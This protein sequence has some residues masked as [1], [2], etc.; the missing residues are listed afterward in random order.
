[1]A[2][3]FVSYR[4]KD[5]D[6]AA[7]RICD[8][9]RTHFGDDQVFQDVE[10]IP[11]GVDFREFVARK[12]DHCDV[13]LVVMGDD[14]LGATG[15]TRR[16]DRPEDLVRLEVETAL[17]RN[18][19]VIPVLVGSKAVP[20]EAELPDTL[21]NLAYRNGVEMRSDGSFDGQMAKLLAAIQA[22]V[23]VRKRGF[24]KLALA[25]AL[26]AVGIVVTLAMLPREPS[27]A[28]APTYGEPADPV[29]TASEE[30]RQREQEQAELEVASRQLEE[31][32]RL[33]Q[34]AEA[35]RQAMER[36]VA[37]RAR[38]QREQEQAELEEANRQLEEAQR[39]K[40]EAEAA[41]LSMEREM[42][43]RATRPPEVAADPGDL[44]NDAIARG[45][46]AA[47]LN[48]VRPFAEAGYADAQYNLGV[49]HYQGLGTPQD[50]AEALRWFR[51]AAEQG[52]ADAQAY[53]NA[54]SYPSQGASLNYVEAGT[55]VCPIGFRGCSAGN[56]C[57][58]CYGTCGYCQ[59]LDSPTCGPQDCMSCS[60]G[61]RLVEVYDDGTGECVR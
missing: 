58:S 18:I 31:A 14:W 29:S 45:D 19:P 50:D 17:Q 23:K 7:G 53:L 60:A 40:Q 47:A 37:D 32:Q 48:L 27:E 20:G 26:V 42:A 3:I 38:R 5:S 39:L 35:A 15:E 44:F 24:G 10:T 6:A 16:I 61:L 4:R 55:E 51:R 12:L 56:Q 43:D 1:M 11:P 13:L 2:A 49:M 21:K 46:Y 30:A 28:L 54:M 25:G 34:E 36:E 59:N 57:T 9:L 33:K 41:R 22:E 8:R 52:N